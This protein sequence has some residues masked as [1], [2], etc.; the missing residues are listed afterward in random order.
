MPHQHASLQKICFKDVDANT[1]GAIDNAEPS[2]DPDD[3]NFIDIKNAEA[4]KSVQNGQIYRV[5]MTPNEWLSKFYIK[6]PQARKYAF[7]AEHLPGE[8]NDYSTGGEMELLQNSTDA[9]VVPTYIREAAATP[10]SSKSSAN[11]WSDTMLG[12]LAVWVVTLS[13]LIL[14]VHSTIWENVKA[15]GLMFAS[16]TLVS[17]ALC[18]VLFEA[19]HLISTGYSEESAAAGSWAAMVMIG[20]LTSPI[21]RVVMQLLM[22]EYELAP[23]EESS[24]VA[25]AASDNVEGDVE[26]S[27]GDEFEQK[28]NQ[29]VEK[30]K[31]DDAEFSILFSMV[32]GDFFHNFADGIF[33]GAAFQCD[34][35]FAWKM[36]GITVAHELP[37]ELGDF[38]ILTGRL[39]YSIPMALLYNV[40]TGL[41]VMLGGIVV[42]AQNLD[43]KDVGMLL[44]YGAGNYLYVATV[45]LFEE[46]KDM[47]S[48]ILRLFWFCV[49]CVAIGLVLLD[50]EHC[51]VGAS[52][53]GGGGGGHQHHRH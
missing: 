48:M 21:I 22:P 3:S 24:A 27:Q 18:L 31:D 7:F 44:A 37:Q 33:I 51:S 15:Y 25:V 6:F 38:S 5:V 26:L 42:C 49:G 28:V 45:H 13:G 11:I 19:T 46:S 8:Y 2:C 52:T 53:E 1:A 40:L 30:S 9:D 50:H 12:C 43:D 29:V 10:S 36:V 17:T 41:S 35:K 47:R 39:G 14:V 16:G 32:L 4:A 34:E 20:F 23:T